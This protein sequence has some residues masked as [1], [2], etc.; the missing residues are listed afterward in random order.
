[1]R[2]KRPVHGAEGKPRRPHWRRADPV[3]TPSTRQYDVTRRLAWQRCADS[4]IVRSA[5]R[6]QCS[7]GGLA[8]WWRRSSRE[9]SC[10]TLSPVSTGMGDRLQAGTLPWYV[11]KPT[12]GLFFMTY[13]NLPGR[14]VVCKHGSHVINILK[15]DWSS[16][17][18]KQLTATPC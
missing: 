9:R 16:M 3:F 7:C 1:M 12:K 11:S 18:N 2:A 17:K 10:S 15:A 5:D 4:A 13:Q 8:Q 6:P 14:C